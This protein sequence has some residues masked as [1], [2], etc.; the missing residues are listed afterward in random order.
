[1]CYY[2]IQLHDARW[3]KIAARAAGDLSDA[4][5]P[6]GA[7]RR[8]R[9]PGAAGCVRGPVRAWARREKGVFGEVA[10]ANQAARGPE[11]AAR[12]AGDLPDAS[13]PGGAPRALSTSSAPRV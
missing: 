9:P 10:R 13:P 4:S 5:P 11:I 8:R 12:A 3:P 6:G 7:A 2:F 1:M